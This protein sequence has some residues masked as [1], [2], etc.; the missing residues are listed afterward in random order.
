M[1]TLLGVVIGISPDINEHFI[2]HNIIYLVLVIKNIEASLEKE[3]Q[4]S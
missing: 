3:K 1:H 2:F 4:R